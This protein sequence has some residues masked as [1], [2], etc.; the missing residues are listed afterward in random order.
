MRWEEVVAMRAAEI[1]RTV[2]QRP[3]APPN[4]PWAMMQVW[5]NL[6]FAHWP[7]PAAT[8]RDL[9]PPNL[10][11]DTYGGDAWVG[12]VPFRM[13][14]IHLHGLPDIAPFTRLLECNVRT[15]VNVDGKPGVYFFSLDADNRVEVE[16]ARAWY[17]LPYFKAHFAY[18][19]PDTPSDPADPAVL[20]GATRYS[21]TRSDRRLATGTFAARYRPI[22]PP[23]QTRQGTLE[24]WLTARYCL[25]TTDRRGRLY[26]GDIYHQPWQLQA[27]EAEIT[28]N[29]LADA[30]DLRLPDTAPLLH[31]SRRLDMVAWPI[32]GIAL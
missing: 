16:V 18:A 20:D 5:R 7:L 29:T 14:G 12:I 8:I 13:T 9:L 31:Y 1:L 3:W 26:R 15:Y 2:D 6:L 27:A 11:L 17:H 22:A 23:V 10:P 32:T 24:D 30:H 25:Y 19:F 21:V 4:R 28:Q